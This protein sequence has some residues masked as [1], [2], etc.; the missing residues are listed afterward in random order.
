MLAKAIYDESG[1]ELLGYLPETIALT[2]SIYELTGTNPSLMPEY[3]TIQLWTLTGDST[4]GD[5][6]VSGE[7]V[8]LHVMPGAHSITW[9]TSTI[10]GS[11]P[12]SL[13]DALN[14]IVLWKV[15]ATL[16]RVYIGS[17]L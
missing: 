1:E 9:P 8:T 2:E 4:L 7:A 14:V 12:V 3:G 11:W 16:Y 13:P 5:G 15:G 17:A 10:I 6:L